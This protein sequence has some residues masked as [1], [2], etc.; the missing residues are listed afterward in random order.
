MKKIT[1]A[2]LLKA[3][4]LDY[5]FAEWVNEDFLV[6]SRETITPLKAT[7]GF[8]VMSDPDGL[9]AMSSI[10]IPEQV[11]NHR[12]FVKTVSKFAKQMKKNSF[13]VDINQGHLI[14]STH[15]VAEETTLERARESID[16]TSGVLL[17]GF[18]EIVQMLRL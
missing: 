13:L 3:I 8:I 15:L 9:M 5:P 11:L 10:L 16:V 6:A 12:K 18:E 7:S 4:E 14:V 2:N 17:S 1:L